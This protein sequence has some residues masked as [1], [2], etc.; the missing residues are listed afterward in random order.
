CFERRSLIFTRCCF[1][2]KTD[3]EV[4][5]VESRRDLLE[6][7]CEVTM[8]VTTKEFINVETFTIEIRHQRGV[9]LTCCLQ[10]GADEKRTAAKLLYEEIPRGFTDCDLL[11]PS[12]MFDQLRGF[13]RVQWFESQHVEQLKVALRV[14][15]GFKDLSTEAGKHE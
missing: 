10:E 7:I 15:R 1:P 9:F 13:V 6:Q 4:T 3:Q 5:C 12:D 14:V 11:A 2:K 8:N